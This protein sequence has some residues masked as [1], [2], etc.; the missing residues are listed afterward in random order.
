MY[1]PCGRET[2]CQLPSNVCEA[3][4]TS[5]SIH[6]LSLRPEGFP[7]TSF[8]FSCNRETLHQ[9][10]STFS[11]AGRPSVN[12]CQLSVWTEDLHQLSVQPGDLLSTSITLHAARRLFVTF[13]Q[14]SAAERNFLN[15][16]EDSVWLGDLPSTS[17]SFPAGLETFRKLPSNFRATRRPFINFCVIERPSVKFPCS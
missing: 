11:A 7:S 14:F 15:F 9:I 5:V 16:H 2:F 1:F 8:T 10:P 12:F 4:R 17:I 13:R 3:W 6:Q